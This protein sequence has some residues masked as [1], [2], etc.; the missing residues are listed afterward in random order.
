M[1]KVE[2]E[3]LPLVTS[4]RNDCLLLV[5]SHF[6]LC[7]LLPTAILLVV[8]KSLLQHSLILFFKIIFHWIPI[9]IIDKIVDP[10]NF[11]AWLFYISLLLIN[12]HLTS[13]IIF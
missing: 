1:N 5:D 11:S 3:L 8:H 2:K 7:F 10:F 12:S 6:F 9:L 13:R 4:A